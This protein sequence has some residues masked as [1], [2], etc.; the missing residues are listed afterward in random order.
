M[1]AG[2]ARMRAWLAEL[3]PHWRAFY[4]RLRVRSHE[5]LAEAIDR[6]EGEG[7]SVEERDE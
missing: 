4:E 2:V 7:G 5:R 3:P 1:S 6:L